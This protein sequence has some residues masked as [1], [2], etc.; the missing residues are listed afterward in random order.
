MTKPFLL[1]EEK[2]GFEP[3][4]PLGTTVF[5][6]VA[7]NHSA[8]SPCL[9]FGDPLQPAHVGTEGRRNGQGPVGF[10]IIFENSD[11]STADR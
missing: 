2:V 4:V 10:L 1:L 6:T 5:K 8:T 3:T 11:E 9:T 7:L